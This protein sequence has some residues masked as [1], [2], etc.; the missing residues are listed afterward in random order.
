MKAIK[1]CKCRDGSFDF[2]GL[3]NNFVQNRSERKEGADGNDFRGQGVLLKINVAGQCRRIGVGWKPDLLIMQDPSG[4][5]WCEVLQA[6][7][8]MVANRYTSLQFSR[9]VIPQNLGAPSATFFEPDA[10]HPIEHF[11]FYKTQS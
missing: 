10:M 4:E 9:P 11:M 8:F 2:V 7:R 5:R 6:G 1:A 3:Y